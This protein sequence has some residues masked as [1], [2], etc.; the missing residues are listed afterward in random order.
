MRT[1]AGCLAGQVIDD[2][3][4]QRF[5]VRIERAR[6]LEDWAK[7]VGTGDRYE[8]RGCDRARATI[9]AALGKYAYRPVFEPL[10][11]EV[12]ISDAMSAR[13]ERR[14]WNLP[15]AGRVGEHQLRIGEYGSG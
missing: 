15:E 12:R 10:D 11:F 3:R 2:H 14:R 4:A 1:A 5:V 8:R 6:L 7:Q 9:D 13:V